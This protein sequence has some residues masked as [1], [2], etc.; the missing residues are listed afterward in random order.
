MDPAVKDNLLDSFTFTHII[1]HEDGTW[2]FDPLDRKVGKQDFTYRELKA[3]WEKVKA[4]CEEDGKEYPDLTYDFRNQYCIT[5]AKV[6]D[7]THYW[8]ADWN[9]ASVCE[10]I[11]DVE[12]KITYGD[13]EA[14]WNNEAANNAD[15]A[16]HGILFEDGKIKKVY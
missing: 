5:P 14:Y 1:L 13:L 15:S 16:D 9:F 2:E 3:A 10:A 8:N 7:N 6:L 11:E 12:E 4:A